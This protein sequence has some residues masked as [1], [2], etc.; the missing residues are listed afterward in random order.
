[1]NML[2]NTVS[3]AV[4]CVSVKSWPVLFLVNCISAN[5]M[6][7]RISPAAL[8]WRVRS[9]PTLFGDIFEIYDFGGY[10]FSSSL[11]TGSYKLPTYF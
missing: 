7:R 11:S 6:S 8:A 4:G 10:E 5:S 2:K 9:N 1:M 3:K